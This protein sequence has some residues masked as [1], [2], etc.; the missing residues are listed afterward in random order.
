M[1]VHSSKIM[2]AKLFKPSWPNNGINYTIDMQA[3]RAYI[4]RLNELY[5]GP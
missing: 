4:S 3:C 1:F 2:T 5:V